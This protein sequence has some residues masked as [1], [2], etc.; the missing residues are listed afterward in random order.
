[1][2]ADE[3]V[4]AT[5]HGLNELGDAAV[6][7][8]VPIVFGVAGYLSGPSLFGGG[9]LYAPVNS[10]TGTNFSANRVMGFFLGAVFV[11]SGL[12][13]WHMG[14][15]D[16]KGIWTKAIGRG[17][18]GFFIGTGA[19]YIITSGVGNGNVPQGLFDTLISSVR[20]VTGG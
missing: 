20:N 6:D 12:A 19:A 13:F 5:F 14:S 8:A 9:S 1:M 18:G 11:I 15:G 7:Y 10:A 16:G 3:V 17:V 2:S 4:P